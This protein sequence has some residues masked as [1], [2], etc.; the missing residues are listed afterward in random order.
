MF[1]VQDSKLLKFQKDSQ[2]VISLG[3]SS[4]WV[5]FSLKSPKLKFF[6]YERQLIAIL[7]YIQKDNIR[8]IFM[9]KYL[10]KPSL[11]MYTI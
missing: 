2:L 7:V 11:F 5:E 8:K 3:G 6:E 9:I 4:C 10:F 1:E